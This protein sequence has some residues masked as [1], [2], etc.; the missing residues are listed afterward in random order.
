M[1]HHG[2]KKVKISPTKDEEKSLKKT[3]LKPYKKKH[4]NHKSRKFW[5]DYNDD[6]DIFSDKYD[7]EE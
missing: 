7:Q 4:V 6:Y 1:A 2:K 3:R 5:Q